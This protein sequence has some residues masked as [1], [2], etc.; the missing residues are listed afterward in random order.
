[1]LHRDGQGEQEKHAFSISCQL[2]GGGRHSAFLDWRSFLLARVSGLWRR[3]PYETSVFHTPGMKPPQTA[4]RWQTPGAAEIKRTLTL[5]AQDADLLDSDDAVFIISVGR[6]LGRWTRGCRWYVWNAS[7]TIRSQM[8]QTILPVTGAVR[9][10]SESS[11][12]SY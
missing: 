9:N 1:M 12:D 8:G 7:N 11:R 2:V 6:V 4:K 3:R 10:L 5:R